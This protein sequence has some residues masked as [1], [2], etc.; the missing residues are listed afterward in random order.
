MTEESQAYQIRLPTKTRVK[1]RAS[2]L[3]SKQWKSRDTCRYFIHGGCFRHYKV[4]R[5]Q[6]DRNQ[7]EKKAA[8]CNYYKKGRCRFS[9]E[10]CWWT[11]A[12]HDPS[13]VK[14]EA[15]P[16]KVKTQTEKYHSVLKTEVGVQTESQRPCCKETQ[17]ECAK[18]EA[19]KDV[20]VQT[21]GQL[22]SCKEV[23]TLKERPTEI[24]AKPKEITP[25]ATIPFFDEVTDFKTFLN[26]IENMAKRVLNPRRKEETPTRPH[27]R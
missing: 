17:T 8:I 19:T 24:R 25:Q 20:G 14:T 11:H 13:E 27:K 21:E 18:V 3:T 1:P 9:S 10:E 23:Q 5:F 15:T 7:I 26:K 12:A 22:S 4:C 16:E 2:Q 6:H